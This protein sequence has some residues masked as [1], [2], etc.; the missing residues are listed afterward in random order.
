MVFSNKPWHQKAPVLSIFQDIPAHGSGSIPSQDQP[1]HANQTSRQRSGA[2]RSGPAPPSSSRAGSVACRP[3]IISR[4]RA[5]RRETAG[6]I[7]ARKP[8]MSS[9]SAWRSEEHT[10]EL[11]SLIR[12]SYA[13]LCWQQKYCTQLKKKKT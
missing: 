2:G 3:C 9:E 8:A 5:R 10:S 13:V 12:N 7:A 11:Q 4:A 6:G 1:P